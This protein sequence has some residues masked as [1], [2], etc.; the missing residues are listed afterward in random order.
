VL[1]I[2]AVA[3]FSILT[4]PFTIANLSPKASATVKEDAELITKPLT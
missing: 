3:V 2:A 1:S 4:D